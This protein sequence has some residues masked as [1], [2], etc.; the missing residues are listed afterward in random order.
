MKRPPA[1]DGEHHSDATT[2]AR[3]LLRQL[4]SSWEALAS[5]LQPE[6]LR[7]YRGS[8][9][10]A[11][12]LHM[13]VC[14]RLSP[15]TS[16]MYIMLTVGLQYKLAL[17]LNCRWAA[18]PR[19]R[20]AEGYVES[21]RFRRA[22]PRTRTQACHRPRRSRQSVHSA[23]VLDSVTPPGV[24]STPA[25]PRRLAART[26]LPTTAVPS[27]AA[28]GPLHDGPPRLSATSLRGVLRQR[29]VLVLG[30]PSDMARRTQRTTPSPAAPT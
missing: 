15:L 5:Q 26:C 7:K 20:M 13:I 16:G 14:L 1:D 24:P 11:P 21:G 29:P 3:V 19:H 8:V 4:I 25:P 23:A 28:P 10:C 6:Y 22:P 2:M 9:A 17:I 27:S 12:A 30:Q 18:G